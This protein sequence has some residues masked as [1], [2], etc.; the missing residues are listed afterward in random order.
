MGV[1]G[2][3]STNNNKL[4]WGVDGG[5]LPDPNICM[6][7]DGSGNLSVQGG[8]NVGG[9]LDY[10]AN[11]Y[12]RTNNGAGGASGTTYYPNYNLFKFNGNSNLFGNWVIPTSS[13]SSGLQILK[14]G[15]YRIECNQNWWS[16][17]YND[18][19]QVWVRLMVNNT[20][21]G[22]SSGFCYGRNYS[23]IRFAQTRINHI[24]SLTANDW[25]KFNCSLAKN[26]PVFGQTWN[27]NGT[28]DRWGNDSF[29]V[30]FLGV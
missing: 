24:I 22:E 7:L 25:I 21:I 19:F 28:V 4:A 27:S 30:T 10:K 9:A 16:E 18:R 14:T 20:I 11:I 8:V 2:N 5:G 6:C 26:T 3:N 15:V 13:S 1:L 17:T 23:N 29:S 12:S